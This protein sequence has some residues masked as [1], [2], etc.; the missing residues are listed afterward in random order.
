MGKFKRT[1]DFIYLSIYVTWISSKSV[2]QAR[3][4]VRQPCRA[5][6]LGSLTGIS[7]ASFTIASSV[8]RGCFCLE[9]QNHDKET[10]MSLEQNKT[11]CEIITTLAAGDAWRI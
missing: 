11:G 8:E 10:L 3:A 9:E 1:T 4:L 2:T 6:M 7:W 5:R